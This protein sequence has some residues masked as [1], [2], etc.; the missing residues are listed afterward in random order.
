MRL[1]IRSIVSPLSGRHRSRSRRVFQLVGKR[2]SIRYRFLTDVTATDISSGAVVHQGAVVQQPDEVIF[3]WR[4]AGQNKRGNIVLTDDALQRAELG[5]LYRADEHNLDGAVKLHV[6]ATK[7]V[8]ERRREFQHRLRDR[9]QR[10][11]RAA[12]I[13]AVVPQLSELEQKIDSERCP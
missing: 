4:A 7:Q 8:P 6:G 3:S 5:I 1:L 13:L 9:F 12:T 11:H 2:V 10:K